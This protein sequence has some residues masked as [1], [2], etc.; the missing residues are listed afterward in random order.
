MGS[1]RKKRKRRNRL[2]IFTATILIV[3][4][5]GVMIAV[6]VFA[7]DNDTSEGTNFMLVDIPL[8]FA[9]VGIFFIAKDRIR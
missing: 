3:F 4:L 7:L 1:V 8:L 2:I 5:I 6:A 9:A